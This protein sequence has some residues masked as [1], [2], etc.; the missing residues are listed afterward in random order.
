MS[1]A[2]DVPLY[3]V[4]DDRWSLRD[5]LGPFADPDQYLD[6]HCRYSDLHLKCGAP[7]RYRY[8][9]DL[10]VLAGGSPLTEAIVRD[11]LDRLLAEAERKLFDQ[12]PPRDVDA[13]FTLADP[14]LN[15]RINAFHD[16]D[17][18]AA[19][20]RVLPREIP[21]PAAIGFP[22]DRIW[23]EICELRQ[24][25]VL[26]TGNTGSGKSTTI[27]SLLDEINRRRAVR[28][29][30]LEDPIEYV[31]RHDKALFSQR[32]LHHHIADFPAGLRSALRED[33][34]IIFVGEMRDRETASLALTAAETGH[35]VF[36]TLHTKDTKGAISRLV[37]LFPAER[38]QEISLQLS[39]ALSYIIGQRLLAR[40]GGGRRVA[41]E[42]LKNNSAVANLI[43]TSTWQQIYSAMETGQR[44][45]MTS[46][47]RQLATLVRSGAVT[48]EEAL[49]ACND[50]SVLTN[51]L[52][53]NPA[54]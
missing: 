45:G 12:A 14:G 54:R 53:I 8:D 44:D 36:S 15:F 50:R 27:A 28:I 10:I 33:P 41:M 35:L 9:G 23:R 2:F 26:L 47:E 5:L 16:R 19:V 7:V 24:G 39:L 42:V 25:L 38:M 20:I 11:I 18:P 46:L 49:L 29:I 37:D 22:E 52:R 40:P 17:G 48:A 4:E 3:P 51:M 30:T 43:R 31:F 21:P 34:D 1:D 13:A 32:E 6:G